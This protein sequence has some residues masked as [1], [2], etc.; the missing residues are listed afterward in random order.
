V[1]VRDY[2]EE[3][4]LPVPGVNFSSITKIGVVRANGQE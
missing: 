3:K 1:G 4:K 2:M